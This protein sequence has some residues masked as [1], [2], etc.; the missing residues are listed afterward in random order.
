MKTAEVFHV[1]R[2]LARADFERFSADDAA[3]FAGV[4][5]TDPQVADNVMDG[6]R[7]VTIVMDGPVI[8]AFAIDAEDKGLEMLYRIEIASMMQAT[9]E[10]ILEADADYRVGQRLFL[11]ESEA[12]DYAS[13]NAGAVIEMR[14]PVAESGWRE[15]DGYKEAM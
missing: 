15:M 5:S 9:G 11:H 1:L 2:L 13:H 14:D 3:M 4:E 12:R 7:P 10:R 6:D 8:Q